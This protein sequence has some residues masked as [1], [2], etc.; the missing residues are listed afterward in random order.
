M[1]MLG[2]HF[3]QDPQLPWAR[4][5]L[6]LGRRAGAKGNRSSMLRLHQ[7]AMDYLDATAGENNEH[8][9]KA[10]LRLRDFDA[11]RFRKFEKGE[12]ALA[13]FLWEICGEWYP[14]K[15]KHQGEALTR[16]ALALAF[17][18]AK[19]QGLPHGHGLG[20]F[21]GMTF[22]LGL[23]FDR[24]LQFPWAQAGGDPDGQVLRTGHGGKHARIRGIASQGFFQGTSGPRPCASLLLG[25]GITRGLRRA[26]EKGHG[27]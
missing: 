17:E 12:A 3:D 15:A 6:A 27:N 21:G 23:G 7:A 20:I 11:G 26:E 10:L 24:D 25:C 5:H 9:I 1:L 18:Q 4:E 2:S 19:K 13:D 16:Q 22:I 8:W 14:Q